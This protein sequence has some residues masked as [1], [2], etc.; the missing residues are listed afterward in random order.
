M[1]P[2]SYGMTW[3]KKNE[4][5]ILWTG[6]SYLTATIIHLPGYAMLPVLLGVF[7]TTQCAQCVLWSGHEVWPGLCCVTQVTIPINSSTNI[8]DTREPMLYHVSMET[9][10]LASRLWPGIMLHYHFKPVRIYRHARWVWP[11]L[12]TDWLYTMWCSGAMHYTQ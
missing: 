2:V 8:P 4:S 7:L 1:A 11:G 6:S 5:Q 10:F 12:C 9:L 3:A